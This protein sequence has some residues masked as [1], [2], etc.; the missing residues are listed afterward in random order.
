MPSKTYRWLGAN[1]ERLEFTPPE[2]NPYTGTPSVSV[3]EGV[4]LTDILKTEVVFLEGDV[5][6]GA[7]SGTRGFIKARHNTGFMVET[8]AGRAIEQPVTLEYSVGGDHP[9]VIDENTVVAAENS[10]V[11]V[12]IKYTSAGTT[13][14]FHAGLTR[15]IAKPGSTVTIVKVQVL[16]GHSFDI[17][18]TGIVALDGAR[19]NIVDLRL[20]AEKTYCGIAAN[21]SGAGA[22]LNISAAYLG[23][24]NRRIDLNYIANQSAKKTQSE[25]MVRGALLDNSQKIFRG[26]IDF[27]RGSAGSR[28]REEEY[29]MLLGENVR[30]RTVPVILCA[31][32]DVDGQHAASTGRIDQNRLFYLMSRGL[33]EKDA[34]KLMIEAAFE[35]VTAQVPD[36]KLR[37]AVSEYVR[38]RMNGIE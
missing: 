6:T 5:A 17:D 24:E 7:G 1:G 14:G 32:E 33:S 9:S 18:D 16:D 27:K 34:K 21:L 15:V 31:E 22:S 11:T 20:G 38:E 10:Q 2:P 12:L 3:P 36:E 29:T 26:T 28:G 19:V 35:P 25:I 13:G 23:E 37:Q 8:Q 4:E 30:N